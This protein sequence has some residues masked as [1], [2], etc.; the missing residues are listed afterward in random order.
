MTTYYTFRDLADLV[1][2]ASCKT[3]RGERVVLV[4]REG[5]EVFEDCPC[6]PETVGEEE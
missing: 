5:V 2:R 4:V 3:C 1:K 6:Q